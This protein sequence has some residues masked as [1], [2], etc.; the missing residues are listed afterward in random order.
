MRR[1]LSIFAFGLILA[2]GAPSVW[3]NDFT[4]VFNC[5][6]CAAIPTSPAVS[7]PSPNLIES[8]G[9]GPNVQGS[10]TLA[11]NDSPGDTYT[12]S[13][14]IIPDQTGLADDSLTITDV[15]TGDIESVSGTVG[16][17]FLFDTSIADSGTLTFTPIGTSATPEPG[18]LGLVLVGIGSL[19][20]A[21]KFR[22]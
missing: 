20:A 19:L 5:T 1:A 8:W 22:T 6:G 12:W 10:F 2:I 7:F 17:D 13:N 3:A 9:P 16:V 4:P 18:T 21:C 11:S 15:T 14:I